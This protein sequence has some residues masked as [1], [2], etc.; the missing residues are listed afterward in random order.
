MGELAGEKLTED[1]FEVKDNRVFLNGIEIGLMTRMDGKKVYVSLRNRRKHFFHKYQGFAIAKKILLLLKANG[2]NEIQL[3]IGKAETLI[4]NIETWEAQGIS[5]RH[6]QYE[7]Q[8]VLPE[9][10]MEKKTL[11]LS[12][13]ME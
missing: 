1:V 7:E 11:S 5:Y 10:F 3:R 9:T 6:P 8:V 4:S 2:F 12:Q 13:L